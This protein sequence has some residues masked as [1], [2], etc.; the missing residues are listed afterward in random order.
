MPDTQPAARR[1]VLAMPPR[2]HHLFVHVIGASSCS[3]CCCPLDCFRYCGDCA[4]AAGPLCPQLRDGVVGC[5]QAGGTANWHTTCGPCIIM[6]PEAHSSTVNARLI[7]PMFIHAA[8][9][10]AAEPHS[11]VAA[12][13]D[14][15]M[16]SGMHGAK[17][18]SRPFPLIARPRE[19]RRLCNWFA[20]AVLGAFGLSGSHN[21][22]RAV[23]ACMGCVPGRQRSLSFITRSR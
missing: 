18:E 19:G 22:Q 8:H 9:M 17:A 5:R 2:G 13:V 6:L 16:G 4:Q 20:A 14:A 3:S 21:C 23:Q 1:L 10:G 7:A 11:S 12:T 15:C